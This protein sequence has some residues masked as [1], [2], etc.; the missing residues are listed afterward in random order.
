MNEETTH[1]I[2]RGLLEQ[3]KRKNPYIQFT[4]IYLIQKA[5]RR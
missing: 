4:A 2:V 3:T 5:L 1:S